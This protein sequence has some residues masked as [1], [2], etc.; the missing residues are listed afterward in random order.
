M[1]RREVPSK[2]WCAKGDTQA[3]CHAEHSYGVLPA[4]P[5]GGRNRACPVCGENLSV[6][7]GDK[8]MWLVWCCQGGC[9]PGVVRL[10]LEQTAG[11]P[12]DCLGSWQTETWRSRQQQRGA[13][14]FPARP[15]AGALRDAKRFYA[16]QQLIASEIANGSLLKMCLQAIS[17]GDGN[18]SGDPARLLPDDRAEFIALGRRAGLERIHC[19][20]LADRWLPKLRAGVTP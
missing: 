1:T 18:V 16:C 20:K 19:H 8:G 9:D 14:S 7:P 11:I 10:A 17:E 13:V 15:D 6:N 4:G 5:G 12:T 3:R 2:S